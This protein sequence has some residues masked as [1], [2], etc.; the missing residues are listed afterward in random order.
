MNFVRPVKAD[1]EIIE[2]YSKP[3]TGTHCQFFVKSTELKITALAQGRR[4]DW[5]PAPNIADIGE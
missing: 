2:I 4:I 3:G 1:Q 5:L